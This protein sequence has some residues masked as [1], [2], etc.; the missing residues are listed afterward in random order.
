[1]K[2]RILGALVVALIAFSAPVQSAY[3][4]SPK[5][6]SLQCGGGPGAGFCFQN[7]CYCY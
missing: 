4:C 3:I 7:V 1:M 2:I 6:C 5:A